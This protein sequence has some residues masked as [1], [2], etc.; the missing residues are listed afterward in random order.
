MYMEKTKLQAK[1]IHQLSN[2]LKRD[3]RIVTKIPRNYLEEEFRTI[4]K[5]ID[6]NDIN[7]TNLHIRIVEIRELKFHNFH[8]YMRHIQEHNEKMEP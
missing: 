8:Q 6:P 4:Y 7:F 3:N 5:N 2:Q 1:T